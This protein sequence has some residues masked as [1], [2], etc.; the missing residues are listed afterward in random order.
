MKR[1]SK[2]LKEYEDKLRL[3][4]RFQSAKERLGRVEQLVGTIETGTEE[5]KKEILELTHEIYEIL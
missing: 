4:E 5:E 1:C 3:F 2:R